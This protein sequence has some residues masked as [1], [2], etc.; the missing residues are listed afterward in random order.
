MMKTQ[1]CCL[2]MEPQQDLE[3]IDI[4]QMVRECVVQSQVAS[5]F[6]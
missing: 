3:F 1:L 5:G 4:T 2:N 6:A